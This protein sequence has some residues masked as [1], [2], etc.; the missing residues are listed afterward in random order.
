M[1]GNY[2]IQFNPN[3]ATTINRI[4]TTFPLFDITV[5]RA[6]GGAAVLG[7]IW[8]RAWDLQCNTGTNPF[9]TR[10]FIYS[11]DSVVTAIDFNGMQP[12]GFVISANSTGCTKTGNP[13]ADRRS[14]YGNV[15]YP[16]YPIFLNDPDQLCFPSTPSYGALTDSIRVTGCDPRNRCINV[17]VNKAGKVEILLDLTA[18]VGFNPGTRDRIIGANV[19]VGNN[20]IPWDSKDGLGVLVPAGATIPVEVNYFNGLTHLPLYDVEHHVNGYK[21]TLIRPAGT[22]P[23]MY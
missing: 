9:N 11:K 4:K 19:V 3:S 5:E 17:P 10:V 21:V 23:R 13:N 1:L 18:P 14:R 2:Y 20:C 15:T 22:A 8:S 6:S 16:E 12:F 7:R